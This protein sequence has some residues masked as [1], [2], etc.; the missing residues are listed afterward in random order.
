[1]NISI[2]KTKT[3]PL[4]GNIQLEKNYNKKS[5]AVTLHVMKAQGGEEA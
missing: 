4:K 3:M 2:N 5:K 1:L